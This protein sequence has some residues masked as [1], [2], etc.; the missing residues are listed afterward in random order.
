MEKNSS[1]IK[2]IEEPEDLDDFDEV[3]EEEEEDIFNPYISDEQL[4]ENLAEFARINPIDDRDP[5][6]YGWT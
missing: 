2:T 3:R 4:F 5:N 6:P 1:I